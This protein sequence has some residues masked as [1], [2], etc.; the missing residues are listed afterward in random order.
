MALAMTL[1]Q[2]KDGRGETGLLSGG[3]LP[4]TLERKGGGMEMLYHGSLGDGAKTVD[5]NVAGH[6]H[7]RA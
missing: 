7:R 4:F 6:I 2:G 5:E 3:L 1:K